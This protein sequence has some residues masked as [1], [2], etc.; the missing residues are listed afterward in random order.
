MSIVRFAAMSEA[1]LSEILDTDLAALSERSR[2]AGGKAFNST[3]DL[4][5]WAELCLASGQKDA[6]RALFQVAALIEGFSP[7]LL[8]QHRALGNRTGLWAVPTQC[9]EYKSSGTASIAIEEIKR[10]S[11]NIGTDISFPDDP[12]P[13]TIASSHQSMTLREATAFITDLFEGLC[14]SEPSHLAISVRSL[15]RLPE[16]KP[17]AFAATSLDVL[18]VIIAVSALREFLQRQL[19]LF[20]APMGSPELFYRVARL[21]SAGLGPYL[22]NVSQVARK[23]NDIFELAYMAADADALNETTDVSLAPYIALLTRDLKTPLLDE[24]VDDLGDHG[25]S[26]C[27]LAILEREGR[28]PVSMINLRLVMRIRDA[29]LDNLDFGLASRGQSIVTHCKPS[30]TLE[31][32]I[33]GTIDASGRRFQSAEQSFEHCLSIEPENGDVCSRLAAVRARNFE[34]FALDHG[35]GSPEDRRLNRLRRRLGRPITEHVDARA[36]KISVEVNY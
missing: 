27:L 28:R 12:E 20:A 5:D 36:S 32:S 6:A 3:N 10:L 34:P 11:R 13:A 29:A 26:A 15:G 14:A 33:L 17:Q 25:M 1:G 21:D 19:D 31:W 24:T 18:G 16:L 23:S 9:G 7:Q 30:S 4:T 2:L 22:R 35:F 8:R